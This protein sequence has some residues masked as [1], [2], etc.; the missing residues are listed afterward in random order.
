[1][2]QFIRMVRM[3]WMVRMIQMIYYVWWKVTDD[4]IVF[5]QENN[6]ST[7]KQCDMTARYTQQLIRFHFV[8]KQ[9]RSNTNHCV[10]Q[11]R[12]TKG[13]GEDHEGSLRA[14]KMLKEASKEAFEQFLTK[15]VISAF[16]TSQHLRIKAFRRARFCFEI[17]PRAEISM[18]RVM[19]NT[20]IMGQIGD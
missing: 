4:E 5:S 17:K 3:I 7:L 1:M 15:F 13:S 2:I 11:V 6:N 18:F 14:W 8:I 10:T 19:K 16:L 9:I 12:I 20:K